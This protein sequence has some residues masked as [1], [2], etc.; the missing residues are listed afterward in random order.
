MQIAAGGRAPTRGEL[1][2]PYFRQKAGACAPPTDA[3]GLCQLAAQSLSHYA[4][5]A[6]L[7]CTCGAELHDHI[8]A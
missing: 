2:V 7:I 6:Q 4:A 3:A 5:E 8:S 1:T